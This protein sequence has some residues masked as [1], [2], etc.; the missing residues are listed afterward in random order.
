MVEQDAAGFVVETAALEMVIVGQ[1]TA[2]MSK[3]DT[4]N[5][6]DVMRQIDECAQAQSDPIVGVGSIRGLC[7]PDENV[8]VQDNAGLDP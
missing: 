8:R 4:G 1:V 3:R 7:M 6:I 2:G 5:Q